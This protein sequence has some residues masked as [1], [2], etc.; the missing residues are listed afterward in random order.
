MGCIKGRLE[1][2]HSTVHKHPLCIQEEHRSGHQRHRQQSGGSSDCAGVAAVGPQGDPL[3]GKD[4]ELSSGEVWEL[5]PPC[6]GGIWVSG[7][8]RRWRRSTSEA[9]LA[10]PGAALVVSPGMHTIRGF[11]ARPA[12][13]ATRIRRIQ[14]PQQQSGTA[15]PGA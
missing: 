14:G 13:A 10:R 7:V 1:M 5:L 2:R 12:A 9:Q 8:Q 6:L 15:A 3:Q 11:V 4:R